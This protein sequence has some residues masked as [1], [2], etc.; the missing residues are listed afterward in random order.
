MTFV[1]SV[2]MVQ[3]AALE[4]GDVDD[5]LAALRKEMLGSSKVRNTGRRLRQGTVNASI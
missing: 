4:S 2:V 5:D 1:V 3:F